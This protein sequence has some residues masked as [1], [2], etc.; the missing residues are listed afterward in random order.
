MPSLRAVFVVSWR[1]HVSNAILYGDLPSQTGSDQIAWRSLWIAGYCHSH[2]ELQ[3][4]HLVLWEPSHG[5]QGAWEICHHLHRH[6]QGEYGG[7]HHSRAL[8]VHEQLGGLDYQ[9][10]SSTEATMIMKMM[11]MLLWKKFMDQLHVIH[12][13]FSPEVVACFSLAKKNYCRG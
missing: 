6:P 2:K 13:S 10:R 3:A 1:D 5:W 9:K 4:S 11:M 7:N 12:P 8:H